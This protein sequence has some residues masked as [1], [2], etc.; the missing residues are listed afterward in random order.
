MKYVHTCY[1]VYIYTMDTH[2][3]LKFYLF[4]L[5]IVSFFITFCRMFCLHYYFLLYRLCVFIDLK[6][7][8]QLMVANCRF[9]VKSASISHSKMYYCLRNAFNG[10]YLTN[11]LLFNK[12]LRLFTKKNLVAYFFPEVVFSTNLST[13]VCGWRYINGYF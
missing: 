11:P 3:S 13:H 5:C 1:T 4:S 12:R 7:T 2:W 6:I 8:Y 9:P 10:P